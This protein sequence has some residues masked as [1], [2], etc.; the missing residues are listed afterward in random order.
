MAYT[1]KQQATL[2]YSQLGDISIVS[3]TSYK[4]HVTS[5][6]SFVAIKEICSVFVKT[7]INFKLPWPNYSFLP[8]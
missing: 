5:S 6:S 4:T 3:I 7:L 1:Q 8:T 2:K